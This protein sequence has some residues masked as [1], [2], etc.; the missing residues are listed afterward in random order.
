MIDFKNLPMKDKIYFQDD[1][2]VIYCGDCR[3]ILPEFED[4]SFDL[5]L[6]DPPYGVEQ[7]AWDSRD[8]YIDSILPIGA[9]LA[10]DY[11]LLWFTAEK[12]LP[13]TLN[14][15]PNFKRILIWDKMGGQGS[16]F[17][18]IWFSTEL[19]IQFGKVEYTNEEWGFAVWREGYRRYNK[20][21][22]PKP[23][24]LIQYLA[25]HYCRQGGIILDPFM[26]SGTTLRAAKNLNRKAVGIEISE[27]YCKIARDRLRQSV[28]KF[29]IEKP[30]GS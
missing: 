17:N 21:P 10:G 13:Q 2:V 19:I 26:G 18:N 24:D 9:M 11:P 29:K 12:Y 3:E 28:L 1:D 20:H 8:Y 22:S 14:A 27:E 23:V 16:A 25:K 6:T 15:I 30:K 4:K 5:V 7:A